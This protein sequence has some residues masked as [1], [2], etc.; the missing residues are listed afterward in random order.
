LTPF[1]SILGS[2]VGETQ[3]VDLSGTDGLLS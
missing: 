2:W 1:V 3:H